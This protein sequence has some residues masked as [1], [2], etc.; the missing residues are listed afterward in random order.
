MIAEEMS[1]IIETDLP[2]SVKAKTFFDVQIFPI[3][4]LQ[5]KEKLH[6]Y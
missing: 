2:D 1:N 4:P 3:N 6:N 5:E